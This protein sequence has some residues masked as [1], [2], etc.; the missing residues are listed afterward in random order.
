M[1][2]TC[3]TKDVVFP[4]WSS[5]QIVCMWVFLFLFVLTH[6]M[7]NFQGQRLNPCHSSDMSHSSDNPGSLTTRPPGNSL[8]QTV[9]WV[10]SVLQIRFFWSSCT[11]ISK[12]ECW[13]HL[14][15]R[16]PHQLDV[17]TVIHELGFQGKSFT[18]ESS[19]LHWEMTLWWSHLSLPWGCWKSSLK[20]GPSFFLRRYRLSDVHFIP[21]WGLFPVYCSHRILE[22]TSCLCL[23]IKCL[24]NSVFSGHH[25]WYWKFKYR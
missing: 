6:G 11:F 16:E 5:K 21:G 8:E 14:C 15:F 23:A 9:K 7:Q 19:S 13:C 1:A 10:V 20:K 3:V 4:I 22:G 25:S 18:R 17:S 12:L 24:L 2:V